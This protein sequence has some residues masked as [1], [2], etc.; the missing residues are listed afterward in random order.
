MKENTAKKRASV[1]R[2]KQNSVVL[3]SNCAIGLKKPKFIANQKTSEISRCSGIT[4]PFSI[5]LVNW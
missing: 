3:T 2:T 1:K 4:N 5:F